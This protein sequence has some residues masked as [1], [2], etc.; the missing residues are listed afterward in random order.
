M[1]DTDWESLFVAAVIHHEMMS[2][3][4]HTALAA[5]SAQLTKREGMV[6]ASI[7]DRVRLGMITD[8]GKAE[9]EEAEVQ[10]GVAEAVDYAARI[11]EALAKR[12]DN[13]PP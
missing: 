11:G 8:T 2:G 1:S 10:K 9:V 5:L 4:S 3:C 7:E 13:G 6:G 12:G